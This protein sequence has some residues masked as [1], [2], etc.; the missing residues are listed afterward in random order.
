[1]GYKGHWYW[2]W[3]LQQGEMRWWHKSLGIPLLLWI[4]AV[5]V[6]HLDPVSMQAT[7]YLRV[8]CLTPNFPIFSQYIFE[9]WVC[10]SCSTRVQYTWMR[11]GVC[12]VNVSLI[13]T[14]LNLCHDQNKGAKS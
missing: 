8:Q 7:L 2:H 12:Q 9:L 14:A 4:K 6:S 10:A 1:M 11:R 5:Y 13:R 3:H